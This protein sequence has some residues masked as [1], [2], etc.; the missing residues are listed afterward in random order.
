MLWPRLFCLLCGLLIVGLGANIGYAQEFRVTS[1]V[2]VSDT[3]GDSSKILTSN[4]TLFSEPLICDFLMSDDVAPQPLEIAIY[5]TRQK[6]FVLLDMNRKIRTEISDLQ[7]EKLVENLASETQKNEASKFLITEKLVEETDW[8][9]GTLSL[10][11]DNMEYFFRGSQPDEPALLPQYFSFLDNFTKLNATDP[12]K[13]PPFPR[14]KLNQRIKQL[15]WVPSEVCVTLKANQ[16]FRENL[17]AHSKHVVTVG[18]TRKDRELIAKAKRDWQ[19]F[20]LVELTDFRQVHSNSSEVVENLAKT[21]HVKK[22]SNRR[23]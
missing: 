15:G 8:T 9:N 23:P 22:Q 16:F 4:L 7:I 13:L 11:G 10:K 17:E 14:M 5:D 18:L 20:K 1:D 2:Y 6:T 3:S 19:T 21:E 12:K